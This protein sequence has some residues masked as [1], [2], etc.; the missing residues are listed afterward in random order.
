MV[1]YWSFTVICSVFTRLDVGDVTDVLFFLDY[2]SKAPL[3]PDELRRRREE[4]QVEIRRQKREETITK[5]RILLPTPGD[6][7]EEEST[8]ASWG[9]SPVRRD[10]C[11]TR[12]LRDVDLR[13]IAC[14]Q[15]DCRCFL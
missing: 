5:R 6:D 12:L 9:D 15:H 2:K 7:S 3:Q 11:C 13:T 14:R 8:G 10:R 4:Q 1:S